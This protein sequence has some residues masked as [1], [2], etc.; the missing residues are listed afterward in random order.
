MFLYFDRN[1]F[2]FKF[3][4]EVKAILFRSKNLTEVRITYLFG[5]RILSTKYTFLHHQNLHKHHT[6]N[7]KMF[8]SIPFQNSDKIKNSYQLFRFWNKTQ[9]KT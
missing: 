3:E 8:P 7:R 9:T 6:K 2:V 5:R 4:M 1:S